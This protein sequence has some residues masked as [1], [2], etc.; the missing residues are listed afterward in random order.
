MKRCLRL[1]P[2]RRPWP[3]RWPGRARDCGRHDV[4][5]EVGGEFASQVRGE[6]VA[7]RGGRATSSRCTRRGRVGRRSIRTGQHRPEA[8][9]AA[10]TPF[11]GAMTIWSCRRWRPPVCAGSRRW[12]SRRGGRRGTAPTCCIGIRAGDR[13]A[14]AG[15][16]RNLRRI[17]SCVHEALRPHGAFWR[18][19]PTIRYVPVTTVE[20]WNEPDNVYFWG[21]HINLS[22]FALMYEAV[23]SAVHRVYGHARVVSGGLAWPESSLPR[24]LRA[25]RGKPLDVV[26][27]HPYGATPRVSITRARDALADMRAYGRGRRPS[28]RTSTAGPQ[29]GMRGG[30]QARDTSSATPT[31]PW[32][33]WPSCGCR[34]RALPVG[35]S[36]L[37]ADHRVVR[38]GADEDRPRSVTRAARAARPQLGLL[39]RSEDTYLY[40]R[41]IPMGQ[42]GE[43]PRRPLGIRGPSQRTRQRERSPANRDRH[44][45]TDDRCRACG[46]FLGRGGQGRHRDPIPRPAAARGRGNWEVRHLSEQVRVAGEVG[47][48]GTAQDYPTGSAVGPNRHRR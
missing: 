40:R 34:D 39:A 43:L 16:Q 2:G 41:R 15:S 45:R 8:P 6:S 38:E 9:P 26:A 4:R 1:L 27:I 11:T 24:L 21:P 23:R 42:L 37:G 3:G 36:R 31:R 25:F 7:G 17:R 32:S 14:A 44:R 47:R 48:G 33:A 28:R 5:A 30:R 12:G 13:P 46:A 18:A 10:T 29:S 35:R 19:N 20:V 22:D